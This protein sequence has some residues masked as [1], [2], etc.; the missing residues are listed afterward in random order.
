MDF[1]LTTQYK[2]ATYADGAFTNTT[3][4]FINADDVSILVKIQ[5]KADALKRKY[6]SLQNSGNI[7]LDGYQSEIKIGD[8]AEKITGTGR[9]INTP[10]IVSKI[11]FDFNSKKTMLAFAKK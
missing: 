3:N 8:Y 5:A 4:G 1:K 11:T 10:L 9:D 6:E 2:D 7:V